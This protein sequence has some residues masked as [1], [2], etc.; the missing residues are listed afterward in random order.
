MTATTYPVTQVYATRWP[1]R[2]LRECPFCGDIA[3]ICT[4]DLDANARK[5]YIECHTCE[6]DTWGDSLREVVEKWNERRD[7]IPWK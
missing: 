6:A 1:N 4:H 2:A 3:K 5:F 7:V